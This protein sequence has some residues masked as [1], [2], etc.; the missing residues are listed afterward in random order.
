MKQST[1]LGMH[2]VFNEGVWFQ[3]KIGGPKL[4]SC[5]A[6]LAKYVAELARFLSYKQLWHFEVNLRAFCAQN[7]P[8]HFIFSCSTFSKYYLKEN[9][10]ELHR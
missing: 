4:V 2:C 9:P 6:F 1:V 10:D 5:N 3:G 8:C 7:A